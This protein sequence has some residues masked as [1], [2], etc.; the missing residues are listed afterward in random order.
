MAEN[1]WLR[2]VPVPT[3]K[4]TTENLRPRVLLPLASS[5]YFSCL[6]PFLPPWFIVDYILESPTVQLFLRE[7]LNSK[8][9]GQRAHAHA[10][11]HGDV[12]H[13][14][15]SLHD[16]RPLPPA[17]SPH[18]PVVRKDISMR[19]VAILPAPHASLVLTFFK[20]KNF[21]KRD[22][23]FRMDTDGRLSICR[24]WPLRSN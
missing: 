10:I 6:S 4:S 2:R 3:E 7:P 16:P 21:V 22:R 11:F 13:G 5:F 24:M 18:S 23:R 17:Y 12:N 9:C 14:A 19:S 15:F 1:G 20:S 8:Q